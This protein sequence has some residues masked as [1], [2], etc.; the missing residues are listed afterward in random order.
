M[1]V[2]RDTYP[3]TRA[4][5]L[6]YQLRHSAVGSVPLSASSVRYLRQDIPFHASWITWPGRGEADYL[7][8]FDGFDAAYQECIRFLGGN[9]R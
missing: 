3:R 6:I 5:F 8:R 7:D 2:T 4:Y 9:R 1:Y